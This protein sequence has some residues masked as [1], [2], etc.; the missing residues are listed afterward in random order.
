MGLQLYQSA[1][2]LC[3]TWHPTC[4]TWYML[5]MLHITCTWLSL[6]H[7]AVHAKD[8]WCWSGEIFKISIC[9]FHGYCYYA[10]QC[11]DYY[12]ITSTKKTIT[13]Q[14]SNNKVFHQPSI[15]VCV[16]KRNDRSCTCAMNKWKLLHKK[17][18]N[19]KWQYGFTKT[20]AYC[21]NNQI[22]FCINNHRA[23]ITQ[24]VVCW[25]RCPAWCSFTD[26]TSLLWASG[27]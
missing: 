22:C 16:Q 26:S 3:T 4:C 18:R 10:F 25:A 21:M 12:S 20:L 2:C 23:G 19:N 14:R 13:R 1:L 11:H 24:S 7:V 8:S 15:H 6:G 17:I 9:A 27:I 5:G